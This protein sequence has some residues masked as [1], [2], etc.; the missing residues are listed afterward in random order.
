MH[1]QPPNKL[2]EVRHVLTQVNLFYTGRLF[3]KSTSHYN[4][5]W[6]FYR[7]TEYGMFITRKTCFAG[8]S[9]D[10]FCAHKH[11]NFYHSICCMYK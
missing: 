6:F 5:E 4:T 7:A 8:K 3:W 10:I 1:V 2:P 9:S 11:D